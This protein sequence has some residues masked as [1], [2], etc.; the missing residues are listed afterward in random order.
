MP[1]YTGSP[2]LCK[3]FLQEPDTPALRI[4]FKAK[5]NIA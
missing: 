3:N 2:E 5:Y 1:D 4:A